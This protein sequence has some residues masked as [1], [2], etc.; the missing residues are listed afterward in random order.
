M[1]V[2]APAATYFAGALRAAEL[3]VAP[4]PTA[5]RVSSPQEGPA[6]TATRL[7]RL[8]VLGVDDHASRRCAWPTHAKSGRP[9]R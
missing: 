6:G 3:S 7:K 2:P 9:V 1:N 4:V 8:G 5:Y